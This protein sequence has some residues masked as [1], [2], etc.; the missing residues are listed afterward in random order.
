M[1]FMKIVGLAFLT[2]ILVAPV[3]KK[4]VNNNLPKK[5]FQPKDPKPVFKTEAELRRIVY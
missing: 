1:T 5:D 2:V 3:V 4:K